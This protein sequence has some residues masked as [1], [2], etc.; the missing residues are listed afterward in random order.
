MEHIAER[1]IFK[2]ICQ[3]LDIYVGKDLIQ[4]YHDTREVFWYLSDDEFSD[5]Y[6]AWKE[7]GKT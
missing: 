3:Q 5:A 1:P 4:S 6:F 2:E 7:K